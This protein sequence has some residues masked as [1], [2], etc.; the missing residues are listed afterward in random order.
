M[1]KTMVVLNLIW[2]LG[3]NGMIWHAGHENYLATIPLAL[4]I[5]LFML[6]SAH[7]DVERSAYKEGFRD[8]KRY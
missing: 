7:E 3:A 2:L 5:Q 4:A 6:L 8:G 1:S